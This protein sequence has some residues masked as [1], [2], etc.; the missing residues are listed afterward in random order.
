MRNVCGKSKLSFIASLTAVAAIVLTTLSG[1][2]QGARAA[3]PSQLSNVWS[4]YNPTPKVRVGHDRPVDRGYIVPSTEEIKGGMKVVVEIF[5]NKKKD[6]VSLWLQ[7]A[8]N[9][10]SG[11]VEVVNIK[12]LSDKDITNTSNYYSKRNFDL[13]FAE[14]NRILGQKASGASQLKIEPGTPLFVYAQ[15]GSGHQWGGV[16]RGGI[17]YAPGDTS[18][19]KNLAAQAKTA[20][21]RPTDLDIAYPIEQNLANLFNAAGKN[22]GIK[23]GGQIRSRVEAEGKFQIPIEDF[24]Q[25]RKDLF[26]LAQ[27]AKAAGK[28]LG[29]GW[30]IKVE[31]RYMQKDKSGNLKKDKDGYPVP[32]PMV[33][34]YYDN[35]NRDAAGN[36]MAIRYR[37]TGGNNT[38]AWNFK[39]GL[40][41][42]DSE[43]VVY[44]VEYGVDTTDDK[45]G[46]VKA[47]ADSQ[48]PLNFFSQI[49]QVIPGSTPS[50]YLKPSVE[51]ADKR[52][53]FSLQHTSGVAIE[54]SLDSVTAKDL[55]KK[56][57]KPVHYV[58]IEMDMEHLALQSNNVTRSSQ[59]NN[60]LASYGDN[61]T[62]LSRLGPKA[63][64]DGRPVIHGP[65]DLKK[66]S[67]LIK[68]HQK[69]FQLATDAVIALRENVI[70]KNW[71]PGA[72]KDAFAAHALGV[73]PKGVVPKSVETTL[74]QHAQ[75]G[76]RGSKLA[77]KKCQVLF[78]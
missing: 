1:I 59:T 45:P 65:E 21:L 10:G 17:I 54:V 76:S 24:D 6:P 56:G 47:F 29:K 33:D 64:F 31:D 9:T 15:F 26:E 63:F 43:G 25:V 39:P 50:D 44:R 4:N 35:A 41:V 2:E 5:H 16:A 30:T 62:F 70:G 12:Q 75:A 34:T 32:D 20:G 11:K 51:V 52:Y 19:S 22:T 49:R 23:V 27:D 71:I 36:D 8:I 48:H 3:N 69:D 72:Q 42:A 73:T 13:T 53:K 7:A 78:K 57:S 60:F 40:T 58:Q 18:K 14:L 28:V 37:W 55:R 77:A 66:S 74:K 46:T 38:G 61:K 67:P 68:K